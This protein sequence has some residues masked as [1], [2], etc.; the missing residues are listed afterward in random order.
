MYKKSE[1]GKSNLK[2]NNSYFGETIEEKVYRVKN[3][4]EPIRDGA[5]QIYT[6][7]KDG[8]QAQ[9]DIRTDRFEIALEAT[10]KIQKSKT[11]EREAREKTVGEQA[12]E[13][14]AKEGGKSEAGG[15]STGGTG[16]TK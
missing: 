11:A 1:Y 3:D 6:A 10:D 7:R 5:P 13:G 14:M 8:V 9:Y 15:Q 12:Q 16:D 4:N 2:V